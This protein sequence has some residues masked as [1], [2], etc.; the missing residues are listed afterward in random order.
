MEIDHCIGAEVAELLEDELIFVTSE[1]QD[2]RAIPPFDGYLNV[3]SPLQLG[4]LANG[5]PNST[6][7]NWQY[8]PN[9]N[10]YFNGCIR[11]LIVNSE[12]YDLAH[13]ERYLKS[14]MKCPNL[15]AACRGSSNGKCSSHGICSG[16]IK[17]PVC[18]CKPGFTGLSC[19]IE[20]I[21]SLF[22][23]QSFTKYALSFT[24]NLFKTEF[25][26][27]FRTWQSY[28]ELFS[29]SDEFSEE[30][31]ILSLNDGHLRFRYNLNSLKNEEHDLWL[32]AITV[33]DGQWHSVAVERYGSKAMLMVDGG[34]GRRFNET[35][36]PTG[37]M[38]LHVD[39]IDGIYAGGKLE[40]TGIRTFKVLNDFKMGKDS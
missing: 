30:Y 25:Q 10:H 29:L 28:G 34:E 2:K 16:S 31:G 6:F 22:K 35:V 4:G 20:T 39:R 9:Q 27:R 23:N 40:F 24:P 26:L 3:S 1:C 12:I 38:L 13:S 8:I 21:P 5:L 32:S 37:H 17:K 11:N 19:N 15:E 14:H 18:K 7:Y 36:L 33:N